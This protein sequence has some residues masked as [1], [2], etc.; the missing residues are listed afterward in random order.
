VSGELDSQLLK[1]DQKELAH[2]RY[3]D[4]FYAQE[5]PTQFEDEAA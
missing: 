5:N 2:S 4:L 3:V 1:A